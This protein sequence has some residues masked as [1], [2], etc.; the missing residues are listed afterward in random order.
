MFNGTRRSDRAWQVLFF[1]IAAAGWP[2]LQA[3]EMV[4]REV[5]VRAGGLLDV[6]LTTGGS[7]EII[8]WHQER[9]VVQ[10]ELRGRDA[11][12]TRVTLKR[13]PRGA[14]VLSRYSMRRSRYRSSHHFR[15]RVPWRFHLRLSSRGGGFRIEN[16]E[17]QVE[18][19]TRGGNLDLR[20]LQGEV[21]LTTL[22][23]DI[24][25]T[26][27]HV[28][29]VLKTVAG[30]VELSGVAGD[31]HGSSLAGAVTYRN[32]TTPRQ[33]SGETLRVS[34]LEGD[35]EVD[36]APAGVVCRAMDG[37]IEI[38][39]AGALVKA[40]T[41]RGDIHVAAALGRVDA[42]TLAGNVEVTLLGFET[43]DDYVD[44]TSHHGDVRLV[45]P[46]RLSATV[47]VELIHVQDGEPQITSFFPLDETSH[48]EPQAPGSRAKH[49]VA[50]G[51]L[52]SGAHSI[53]IRA[54]DGSVSLERGW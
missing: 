42:S 21:R 20:N 40:S 27:A 22:G 32:V 14:R 29:G 6:E 31:I 38:G 16:L 41:M 7:L 17:G 19:S 35:I 51:T 10:G 53:R 23:G 46:E 13:T 49:V 37:D 44:L 15:I 30:K 2:D 45:F 50:T 3:A 47:E 5:P 43:P 39:S 11:A 54:V 18:G 33:A 24:S 26:N 9:V 52:G 28:D 25:L 36:E 12:I 4:E 34:S 8:G 48:P 1:L